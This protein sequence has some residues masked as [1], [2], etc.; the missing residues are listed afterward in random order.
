LT[1][2]LQMPGPQIAIDPER[3]R[4]VIINLVDNA[5][6]AIRDSGGENGNINVSCSPFN[7]GTII[8]VKDNGLGIPDDVLDRMFEPL[9]TTKSFGAGLG[10]ATVKQLV[11]Q[12]SADMRID[13]EVGVGSIFSVVLPDPST[14][15][16]T[17]KHTR[18]METAI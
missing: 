8:S 17:D 13:T 3:F 2:D 14:L 7:D 10:L 4:R 1:R 5:A 18:D 16:P 15:I 6:Q 9:F 11:Q 12:H